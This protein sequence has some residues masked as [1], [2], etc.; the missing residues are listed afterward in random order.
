MG[1]S[2][3][4]GSGVKADPNVTPMIDV[5]LVLLVIFMIGA[6]QVFDS[7]MVLTQGGPGDSSRSIVIYIYNKAFMDFNMGYSSA[8]SMT[9]SRASPC[10]RNSSRDCG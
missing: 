3:G 8:I 6:V 7:I 2:T 5:M 4:G 1:M 10:P 9:R